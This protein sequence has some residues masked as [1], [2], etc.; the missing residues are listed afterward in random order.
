M[1]TLAQDGLKKASVVLF[2]R[3]LCVSIIC[4]ITTFVAI[5]SLKS[6]VTIP[7]MLLKVGHISEVCATRET[8]VLMLRMSRLF[9]FLFSFSKF[10]LELNEFFRH[11][12]KYLHFVPLKVFIVF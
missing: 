4:C 3:V 9:A 11:V 6:S 8:I 10:S 2:L 7:N 1:L 12:L 5:T